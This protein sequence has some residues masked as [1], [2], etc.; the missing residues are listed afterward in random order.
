MMQTYTLCERRDGSFTVLGVD[1][2]Y[3]KCTIVA[4]NPKY[5]IGHIPGSS[6]ASGQ[7]RS[8]G[9][10]QLTVFEKRGEWVQDADSN[11]R[12]EVNSYSGIIEV[13]IGRGWLKRAK[14]NRVRQTS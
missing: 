6:Y 1:H 8:Y 2:G 7:T 11:R 12:I 3:G 14:E 10:P 5:L 9:Q 13:N 4:E